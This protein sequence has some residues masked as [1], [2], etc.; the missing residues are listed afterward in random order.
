MKQTVTLSDVTHQIVPD[1]EEVQIIVKHHPSL[2]E[3]VQL[4]AGAAEVKPLLADEGEYVVLEVRKGDQAKHVVVEL[5][6]FNGIFKDDPYQAL[7]NARPVKVARA[8][9]G[10]RTNTGELAKIRE[11]ATANG[12]EVAP[13]G[14]VKQDIVDAYHAAQAA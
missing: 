2:Q 10:T 7:A 11:W 4:D 1:G 12:Y 6:T 8:G 5:M 14:R 13:K 3:V 9:N